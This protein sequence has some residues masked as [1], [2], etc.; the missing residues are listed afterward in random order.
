MWLCSH[1]VVW[2]GL[3]RRERDFLALSLP[4]LF[5]VPGSVYQVGSSIDLSEDFLPLLAFYPRHPLLGHLC[6]LRR[7]NT[8]HNRG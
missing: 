7:R 2:V 5:A 1:V 8:Y 4:S 3:S 6:F